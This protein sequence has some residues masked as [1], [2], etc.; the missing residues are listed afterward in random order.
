MA[1]HKCRIIIIII[2]TCVIVLKVLLNPNKTNLS[3]SSLSL[4]VKQM[5]LN[6]SDDEEAER[7][8]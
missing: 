3:R 2:M 8:H 1:L 5:A 7:R 6:T 4:P